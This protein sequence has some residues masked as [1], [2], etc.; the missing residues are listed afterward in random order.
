MTFAHR[1]RFRASLMKIGAD[2]LAGVARDKSAAYAALPS[3]AGKLLHS[4]TSTHFQRRL[5]AIRTRDT[6]RC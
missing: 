4:L 2:G 1:L 5:C 6:V 3:P